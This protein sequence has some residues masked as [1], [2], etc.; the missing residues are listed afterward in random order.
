MYNYE[1]MQKRRDFR[2][3]M[4]TDDIEKTQSSSLK[5]GI[6]TIRAT[7]PLVP[8]YRMPGESEV[9]AAVPYPQ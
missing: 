3:Y 7:N 8:R 1:V 9:R 4:K 5:K 6:N 2:N